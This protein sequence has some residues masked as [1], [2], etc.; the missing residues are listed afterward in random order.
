MLIVLKSKL[1][2]AVKIFK[3]LLDLERNQIQKYLNR[4]SI[5]SETNYSLWK[6]TKRLKQLQT[7]SASRNRTIAGPKM[8]IIPKHSLRISPTFRYI[9]PR[10]LSLTRVRLH[11]RRKSC[12]W[13]TYFH[14]L[15]KSIFIKEVR[16]IMKNLNPRKAPGYDT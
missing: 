15:I 4:L 1:N 3:Y 14:N 10:F 16:A 8:K 7:I 12:S 13:M 11:W 6:T 5:T 9:S 2:R